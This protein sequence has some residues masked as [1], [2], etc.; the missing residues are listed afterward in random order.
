MNHPVN[1]AAPQEC[2][3]KPGREPA[4]RTT[5]QVIVGRDTPRESPPQP[6]KA[7]VSRK[8]TPLRRR[9]VQLILGQSIVRKRTYTASLRQLTVANAL[10][11]R[12]VQPE[13]VLLEP[14]R[15]FREYRTDP[16][17]CA[18]ASIDS[19]NDGMS[20][21]SPRIRISVY[22]ARTL[23]LPTVTRSAK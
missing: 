23:A 1:H 6:P 2:S 12:L 22:A 5:D 15:S 8:C 11:D 10:Q 17:P 14:N 21:H 19:L 7:R 18:D 13:L 9:R 4:A 16:A 3:D 20:F